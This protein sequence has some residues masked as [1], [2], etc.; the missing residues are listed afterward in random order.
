[1]TT[2]MTSR[3]GRMDWGG[4]DS[5]NPRVGVIRVVQR[6]DSQRPRNC[7]IIVLT[8]TAMLWAFHCCSFESAIQK[9]T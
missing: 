2:E 9:A 5:V 8:P 7:Q 1:M 4:V 3:K 6:A